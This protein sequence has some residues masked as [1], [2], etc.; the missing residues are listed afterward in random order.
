MS[1]SCSAVSDSLRPHG[2]QPS[3]LLCP[4]DS[5]ARTLEWATL[6]SS[7]GSSQPRDR[8]RVSCTAGGFFT[9]WA[10]REVWA[11]SPPFPP[12]PPQIP[13]GL[14]DCEKLNA[15]EYTPSYCKIP[16][17]DSSSFSD[18]FPLA[19]PLKSCPYLTL[20]KW[21]LPRNFWAVERMQNFK[22]G[23]ED[24]SLWEP[25]SRLSPPLACSSFVEVAPCPTDSPWGW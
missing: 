16:L 15:F 1:A 2:L 10:P 9:V 12:L 22:M 19:S 5:P 24:T 3:R 14:L 18:G 23:T 17:H 21:G 25:G 6:P 13:T 4:C 11:P 8:T 7:R 20:L